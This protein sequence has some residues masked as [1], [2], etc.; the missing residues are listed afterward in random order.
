MEPERVV[1]PSTICTVEEQRPPRLPLR[2][3]VG[4]ESSAANVSLANALRE[5]LI[6]T[7]SMSR[8]QAPHA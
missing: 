7:T 6:G 5:R 2:V 3:A 8:G 4:S 1:L